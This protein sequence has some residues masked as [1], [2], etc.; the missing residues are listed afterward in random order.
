MDVVS[1]SLTFFYKFVFTTVW[2][3]GFG[4]GTLMMFLSGRPDTHE[5]RWVFATAWAIGTAFIWSICARLKRVELD[6]RTLRI[7]NYR[8]EIAVPVTQVAG[9]RQNRLINLRPVTVTFKDETRFGRS[10]TFIPRTSFRFF[11]EDEVVTKL[12]KLAGV[13]GAG[14]G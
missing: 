13:G 5:A 8:N 14:S 10:V 12:R 3:G 2:S 9:V 6:D 7:S 11:S 1:S 4:V